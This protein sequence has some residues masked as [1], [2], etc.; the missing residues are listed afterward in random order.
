M[1]IV[2]ISLILLGVTVSALAQ[3]EI[4]KKK[5]SL[6]YASFGLVYINPD[7][8]FSLN[9]SGLF[10]SIDYQRKI[11]KRFA[12][13]TFVSHAWGNSFPDFFDNKQALHDFLM[14][15]RYWSIAFN[16]MWEKFNY[17]S[18]GLK[19]YYAPIHTKGIY[20]ALY[21]GLGLSIINSSYYTVTAWNYDPVTGQINW[22]ESRLSKTNEAAFFYTP[23]ILVNFFNNRNYLL[24]VNLNFHGIVPNEQLKE[25][26][27]N[28]IYFSA[29]LSARI[30][31]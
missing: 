6:L 1:K 24:G 27:L 28:G 15:Q 3:H 25:P 29:S 11:S 30:K 18:T 12:Y 19:F 17:T 8:I 2:S 9:G 7:K 10:L 31:F 14:N 23:G 22:Y 21:L 20:A 5:P 16:S 4:E 26:V 13:G